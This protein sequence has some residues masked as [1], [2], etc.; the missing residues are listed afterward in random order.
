MIFLIGSISFKTVYATDFC[1][2]AAQIS[3]GQFNGWEVYIGSNSGP[4]DYVPATQTQIQKFE[5]IKKPF[6]FANWSTQF[7]SWGV[8]N[9]ICIYDTPNNLNY[10]ISRNE[11][12]PSGPNWDDNNNTY[13]CGANNVNL[14]PFNQSMLIK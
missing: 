6:L 9:A 5:S 8:Q 11:Q 7:I 3:A 13:T 12:P 1:P 10:L 14:C 2:S 4:L